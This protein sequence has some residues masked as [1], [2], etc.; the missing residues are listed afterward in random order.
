MKLH[1]RIIRYF[2]K[3]FCDEQEFFELNKKDITANER[4]QI[5]VEC[6]HMLGIGVLERVI[7][8]VVAESETNQLYND[9]KE[10]IY[11]R[12]GIA[13]LFIKIKSFANKAV[14]EDEKIEKYSVT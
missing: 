5:Y 2:Y 1:K 8:Q 12:E 10:E 14:K 3:R 7:D 6:K 13:S 4:L 11:R 9:V